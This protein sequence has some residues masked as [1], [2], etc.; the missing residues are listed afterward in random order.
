[1]PT[2]LE[3]KEQRL[4]VW[5][6]MKAINDGA[7]S[8]NR[9]LSSEEQTNWTAANADLDAL[10]KRIERQE[11]L[12]RTPASDPEPRLRLTPVTA[13]NPAELRATKE[14][15]EAFNR[16][17]VGL[18]EPE[19]RA[20]MRPAW[21]TSRAL[22]TTSGAAGGFAVPESLETG[23]EKALLEYGGMREVA[24]VRRTT[25]GGDLIYLTGDDTSNTGEILAEN[26]AASEQDATIAAT[27][28]KAFTYSSKMIRVS[29]QLLQDASFDVEGWLSAM[30][31]ERIGRITNTHFTTGAG[32]NMPRGVVQ[33]ATSGVA[34]ATGQ[35]TTVTAD[36]I[37]DLE[38]SVGAAYR[39]GARYMLADTSLAIIRKL[40][41][42]E[43]RYL[44]QPGSI[45]GGY[46]SLLNN[47][48]YVINDDVAAMAASA[49][50][51]LFGQFSHYIIR[52][53]RGWTLMRLTE[54]YAEY[55]QVAF[56]GFSRH[57][58]AL[59]DAGQHPV[60][61]YANSAT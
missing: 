23:V 21:V 61:Y 14:Y 8:E 25:D 40:K 15:R 44:W 4:S 26:T 9:D 57:D 49:K 19:D 28:L 51:L 48:P 3:L 11:R 37:I 43:G 38:H 55:M 12:E 18:D 42:G 30:L 1:M 56:L 34:G 59:V 39:R 29:L 46:P 50:S 60:K 47:Y 52:D 53:V 16:W 13:Y 32:A 6:R 54:R 58:G 20:I 33:G 10:D 5:N 7:E 31:A 27:V 45:A 41:D 22:G 36:N 24:T 35:T 17:A 2:V